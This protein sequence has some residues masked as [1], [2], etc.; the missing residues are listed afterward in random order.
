VLVFAVDPVCE[1][2]TAFAPATVAN[3]GP[4]F[5]E[6]LPR[7]PDRAPPRPPARPRRHP[8]HPAGPRA[9]PRGPAPSPQTG[10]GVPW[11]GRGTS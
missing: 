11:M 3:L 4:G 8:G 9:D 2:A 1:K 10:W 5:G 7:P 6:P